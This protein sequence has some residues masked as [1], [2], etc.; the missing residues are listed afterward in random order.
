MDADATDASAAD[1]A[2]AA[3]AKKAAKA[4]SPAVAAA[5]CELQPRDQGASAATAAAAV[6]DEHAQ[7]QPS[8]AP[9][10]CIVQVSVFQGGKTHCLCVRC[11]FQ[12]H[13]NMGDGCFCCC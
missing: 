6:G 10:D 1:T 13:R 11:C 3:P 2:A 8:Y 7:Q 5:A 9:G 4:N 12:A